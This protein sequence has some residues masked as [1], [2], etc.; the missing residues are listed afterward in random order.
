M[1]RSPLGGLAMTM[2]V[3]FSFLAAA[4]AET[5]AL[6]DIPPLPEGTLL[7]DGEARF[8][9]RG[10]I[11][12][13]KIKPSKYG[14]YYDRRIHREGSTEGIYLRYRKANQNFR[15]LE[16]LLLLADPSLKQRS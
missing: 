7:F 10:R 6:K 13:F 9:Q 14:V 2:M 5:V 11:G 16:K 8:A 3:F 1:R 15:L 4:Y 12:G